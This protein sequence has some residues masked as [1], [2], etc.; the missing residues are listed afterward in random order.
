MQ[1]V[2]F[3]DLGLIDYQEAW[4]YQEKLFDAIIDIKKNR[5]S[6]GIYH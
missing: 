4:T 1:K 2:V 5:N 3:K 6:I